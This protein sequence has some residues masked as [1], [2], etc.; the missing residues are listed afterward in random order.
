MGGGGKKLAVLNVKV[1]FFYFVVDVEVP[2]TCCP[3]VEGMSGS[4]GD[5]EKALM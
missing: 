4:F 5:E 1:Y 2:W 3:S